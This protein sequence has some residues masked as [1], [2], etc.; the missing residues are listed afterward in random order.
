MKSYCKPLCH[1]SSCSPVVKLTFYVLAKKLKITNMLLTVNVNLSLYSVS[2][3]P[4]IIYDHQSCCTSDGRSLNIKWSFTYTWTLCLSEFDLRSFLSTESEQLIWKS[5]GLPSDDLSMENAL[6]I[7]Q[8][9]FLWSP[10]VS[11]CGHH[12]PQ[13]NEQKWL[14][15]KGATVELSLC[16]CVCVCWW[17]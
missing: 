7:L 5:Q 15:R 8:V 12:K 4:S 14:L 3:K 11:T 16:M 1:C 17:E 13:I 6:V 2:W 10:F 9:D